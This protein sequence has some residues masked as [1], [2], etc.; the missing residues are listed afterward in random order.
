[1]SAIE[2]RLLDAWLAPPDAGV[3]VACL[4]T[5]FTFDPD[6]FEEECLARFLG[7]DTAVLTDSSSADAAYYVVQREQALED[8][9]ATVLVD[10]GASA[11]PTSRRWDVVPTGAPPGGVQHAK[12]SVLLWEHVSRVI[13]GSA[14]LTASGYRSNIEVVWTVDAPSDPDTGPIFA[15][16][17]AFLKLLLER[18]TAGQYGDATPRGRARSTIDL[19]RQRAVELPTSRTGRGRPPVA[20]VHTL[21]HGSLLDQ[22]FAR[23]WRGAA[24]TRL[25]VVSPYFVS[26][27]GDDRQTTGLDAARARLSKR[28]AVQT[29]VA[30][31][32]VPLA[33]GQVRIEAPVEVRAS[34]GRGALTFGVWPRKGMGADRRLHAKLLRFSNDGWQMLLAGSANCTTAGLGVAAAPRNVELALVMADRPGGPTGRAISRWLPSLEALSDDELLWQQP[35]DDGDAA[36]ATRLPDKFREALWHPLRD[37]VVVE[38][39][40]SAP[41]ATWS[42]F[43]GD[44]GLFQSDT[45]GDRDA[46]VHE[47]RGTPAPATLVV[48]WTDAAGDA[49][50][51]ELVVGVGDRRELPDPPELSELTFEELLELLAAGGRFR[52]AMRRILRRRGQQRGEQPFDLDPHARVDTTNFVL[53]RMRRIGLALEGLREQ[54]ERP[55][56]HPEAVVR[57]LEGRFGP[58]ALR[59]QIDQAKDD[60]RIGARERAFVI[61]E[62][63]L[64]LRRV[65][66]TPI[67]TGLDA[68]W[69]RTQAEAT[70]AQIVHGLEVE[71][72]AIADYVARVKG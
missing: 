8:V 7:L 70:V 15:A 29:E 13:V 57:R 54:L 37:I 47:L 10:R 45:H 66:W 19:L 40:P 52:A 1:M 18:H 53:P 42:I 35:P 58:V 20:V 30:V 51:G 72:D 38:L 41:P 28:G 55:V 27:L 50:T 34:R 33:G 2:R 46:L 67:G 31:T 14:N 49:K 59:R 60:G 25:D 16:I 65:R 32:S 12:V 56:A 64:A 9:R 17:A 36:F 43:A 44:D 23:C 39:D 6:F 3:P 26:L 71:D 24:P 4:S 69:C 63:V 62:L 22:A 61:A 21:D 11:P 68:E 48:Q 5:T